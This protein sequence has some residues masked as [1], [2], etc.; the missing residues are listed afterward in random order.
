MNTLLVLF[1]NLATKKWNSWHS[2][3]K[4]KL[5]NFNQSQR[6]R[7]EQFHAFTADILGQKRQVL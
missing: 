5:N 7:S 3:L 1:H 4:N 6:G 2:V